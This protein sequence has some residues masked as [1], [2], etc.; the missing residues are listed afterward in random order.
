MS[1]P[2]GT[3]LDLSVARNMLRENSLLQSEHGLL[4][5]CASPCGQA[6]SSSR[7]VTQSAPRAFVEGRRIVCPIDYI[8]AR[9][10]RS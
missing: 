2:A 10:R 9:T 4:L 3:A 7:Q 8:T 5:S 1:L 6:I